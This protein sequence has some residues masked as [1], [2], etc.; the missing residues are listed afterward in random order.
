MYNDNY[1]RLRMTELFIL[2]M[3]GTIYLGNQVFEDA[4]KFISKVKEAGKKIV[5]FTNNASKNPQIYFEKLLRMGFQA[6]RNEIISAGDVTARYLL[7]Y[8]P[9]ESV[10][11]VGTPALEQSFQE[12]GITL[13]EDATIVVS[14]FDTTLTYQKLETACNLIRNGATYY[15][16]HPDFNCPTENGFIPDSG[17]IAALI[18]ASTGTKPKYFGKPHKE[19]ADLIAELFHVPFE[20]T[21]MV[22]DRLYTDIAFGKNN[23]ILSILVLTG[24]TKKEDIN[25]KNAPDLCFEKIGDIL[26][27]LMKNS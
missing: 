6:E 14:S 27:F 18:T 25:V 21:A 23:G 3:D 9:N 26:Q 5:Y 24:E 4:V 16:T 8:H 22:G 10:Y 13:S 17:A 11:L 2:D 1:H 20:K 15:C 7:K 19:S 12:Y